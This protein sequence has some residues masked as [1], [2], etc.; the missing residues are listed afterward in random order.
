MGPKLRSN[1]FSLGTKIS[2]IN[3]IANVCEETGADVIESGSKAWASTTAIG[4]KFFCKAGVRLSAAFVPSRRTSSRASKQLGRQLGLNHFQLLNASGNRCVNELQ[5]S[6]ASMGKLEKHLGSLIGQE[7][8]R[9]LGWP[10]KTQHGM[11]CRATRRPLVL[12]RPA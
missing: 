5:R 3:E 10:F 7:E 9:C 1:A 2:F 12:S 11:T 6:V 8:S 4:P